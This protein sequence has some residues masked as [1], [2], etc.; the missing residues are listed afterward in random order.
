MPA[1]EQTTTGAAALA[2]ATTT[3]ASSNS[4]EVILALQ[5]ERKNQYLSFKK[6]GEFKNMSSSS[7]K[8]KGKLTALGYI[9]VFIS[10]IV[11][12][13]YWFVDAV[14][15]RYASVLLLAS[16]FVVRVHPAFSGA[17]GKLRWWDV[18]EDT[19]FGTS[20]RLGCRSISSSSN[21]VKQSL[22]TTIGFE[23]AAW[24]CLCVF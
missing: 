16:C 21:V 24:V 1:T 13:L 3:A 8:S 9:Y 5:R 4:E 23:R 18:W 12:L 17:N 11:F 7:N 10:A 19:L 14:D 2:G 6:F 15:G 20:K 22:T